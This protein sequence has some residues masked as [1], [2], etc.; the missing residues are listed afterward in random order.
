M[1]KI[2]VPQ[3]PKAWRDGYVAGYEAAQAEPYMGTSYDFSNSRCMFYMDNKEEEEEDTIEMTERDI[4]RALKY[5]E[6]FRKFFKECLGTR[7][8]SDIRP[9]WLAKWKGYL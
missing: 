6:E 9:K 7:D 2:K 8:N 1:P 4:T 5:S 3:G